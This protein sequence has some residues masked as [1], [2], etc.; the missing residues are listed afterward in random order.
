MGDSDAVKRLR[1]LEIDGVIQCEPGEGGLPKVS[2]TT[3]LSRAEVYLHGAQVTLF[4]TAEE[5][6]LL[7][8]SER[9]RFVTGTPI[10][11]GIP[12]CYPWFGPR[13]GDVSHG[14]AR[15]T[16]WELAA[17]RMHPDGT[18]GLRFVLPEAAAN[19]GGIR[20][21]AREEW[22]SLK[23]ELYVSV[24]DRLELE[25][26]VTNPS[27]SQN[28]ALENCFHTYFAISDISEIA[29]EGLQGTQYRD[30]LQ[31][32]QLI[33]DSDRQIRI[34]SQTDRT[35]LD[36]SGPVHIHDPGLK[37]TIAIEKAGSASTVVWNPWTTQILSD[38]GPE[39]YRRLIC[40][41]SGNVEKNQVVLAP[42][43]SSTLK[44]SMGSLPLVQASVA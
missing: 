38:L 22:T 35:Y 30:R 19:Q 41:E 32:D 28:V 3:P 6:P 44:V 13:S 1:P 14:Y 40:V 12:I 21:G 2:V 42:G 36:A 31:H 33:K 5:P 9:S 8:L 43:Q 39:E 25:L 15:I 37:R 23:A 20:A 24:S 34:N 17:T 4:K 16:E 26:V 7:F 10:R 29:I 27:E 11:G 18:A